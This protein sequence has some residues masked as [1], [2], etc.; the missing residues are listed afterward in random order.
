[1]A[2]ELTQS[3]AAGTAIV[4]YQGLVMLVISSSVLAARQHT[5]GLCKQPRD[6]NNATNSV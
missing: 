4:L 1:M 6:E 5:A 2:Q 3:S